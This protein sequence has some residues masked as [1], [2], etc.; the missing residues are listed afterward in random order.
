MGYLKRLIDKAV[1]NQK[2]ENNKIGKYRITP[3]HGVNVSV[4]N[5]YKENENNESELHIATIDIARPRVIISTYGARGRDIVEIHTAIQNNYY[6][7][8]LKL[9]IKD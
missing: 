4:F 1:N 6:D 5:I 7:F 9:E 3:Q 8:E 2:F